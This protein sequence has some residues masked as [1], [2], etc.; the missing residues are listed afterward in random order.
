MGPRKALEATHHLRARPLRGA[1]TWA[2]DAKSRVKI[3]SPTSASA[4]IA[5]SCSIK[6]YHSRNA[7]VMK[8][9]SFLPRRPFR[10]RSLFQPGG[11][12]RDIGGGE[13]SRQALHQSTQDSGIRD[14]QR[15]SRSTIRR[16]D[17]VKSGNAEA[18][19]ARGPCQRP[20]FG[21]LDHRPN[22]REKLGLTNPYAASDNQ[23]PRGQP[24]D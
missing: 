24:L 22:R 9:G 23:R 8:T 17:A 2:A 12:D 15:D 16:F 18:K 10:L 6:R 14:R 7:P 19:S 1:R 4:V 3:T 11:F 13:V 21:D 20:I 5:F